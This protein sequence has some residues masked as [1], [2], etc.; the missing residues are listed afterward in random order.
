MKKETKEKICK[1]CKWFEK[2]K[3][4]KYRG[5]CHRYPASK[6]EYFD[7]SF[8]RTLKNDFCGEFKPI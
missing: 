2:W 3:N 4:D 6:D 8:P 5:S 7:T 1:N